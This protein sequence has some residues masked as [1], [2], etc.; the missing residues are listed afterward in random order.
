MSFKLEVYD[1]SIYASFDDAKEYNDLHSVPTSITDLNI[2]TTINLLSNTF[3]IKCAWR[4]VPDVTEIDTGLYN[5]IRC[6]LDDIFSGVNDTD[7][8]ATLYAREI[9]YYYNEIKEHLK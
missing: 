3:K 7:E 6:L 2:G 1:S 5:R 8:N 4:V 9:R